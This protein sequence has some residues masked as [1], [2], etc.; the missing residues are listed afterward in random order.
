MIMHS[1]CIW[2]CLALLA[3]LPEF[4]ISAQQI[5]KPASASDG[6]LRSADVLQGALWTDSGNCEVDDEVLRNSQCLLQKKAESL[7]T[8]SRKVLGGQR[9]EAGVRIGT[10]DWSAHG[11]AGMLKAALVDEVCSEDFYQPSQLETDFHEHAIAWTQDQ[12]GLCSHLG[13]SATQWID[14]N[15]AGILTGENTSVFSRLCKKG[16]PVQLLEPLAG[17]LR[18]PRF[19]CN[20][21]SMFM[22]LSIE[23]LVLADGE[24]RRTGSVPSKHLFFDAGG[25]HFSDAMRFFT[26]AYQQRG[27]VFDRIYAWEAKN[28][29]YENYWID[30]PAEV[31][32]F[33]E[34]RVTFYNGVP[35]SAEPGNQ[36]NPVERVYELCSP[37]DFCAFKLDI[38][39]PLVELAITQQL[40]NSPHK[41]A[42]SLDEFF[43]EH[44]VNGLMEHFGWEGCTNGTFLD[45]YNLF[46]ALRHMGVRAHSWI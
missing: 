31:R 15:K 19:I 14:Q 45:S 26:S 6:V 1:T 41:T 11:K 17:I 9:V 3:S 24:V 29:T 12:I 16:Y 39:T 18:D 20:D 36:N 38:D 32:Q 42:A 34:P 2:A 35:V 37:D 13:Q 43:F 40:L 8:A 21:T 46:S 27:I 5:T 25:S 7:D 30:V 10:R 28:Q 4:A 23:W 44:H 22:L 33:W